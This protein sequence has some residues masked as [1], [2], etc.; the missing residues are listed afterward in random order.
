[1]PQSI[2]MSEPQYDPSSPVTIS[3]A[4]EKGAELQYVELMDQKIS[5][6]KKQLQMKQLDVED[7]EQEL[8]EIKEERASFITLVNALQETVKDQERELAL[9]R[10]EVID[11]EIQHGDDVYK[12]P[13]KRH[14]SVDEVNF[15]SIRETE[16]QDLVAARDTSL[17]QSGE[18]AQKLAESRAEADDLQER[19]KHTTTML[20][21][22]HNEMSQLHAKNRVLEAALKDSLNCSRSGSRF[23]SGASISMGTATRMNLSSSSVSVGGRSPSSKDSNQNEV[24]GIKSPDSPESPPSRVP[25]LVTFPED[26]M[27]ADDDVS[28]HS[29]DLDSITFDKH[30]ISSHRKNPRGMM[31][32]VKNAL[33]L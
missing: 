19:L 11:R 31:G 3:S 1:M 17:L 18:L 4:D 8:V 20:A 25:K 12:T 21:E 6:L 2:A 14:D 9:L 5:E 28:M 26:C 15:V 24:S 33:K 7:I 32:V 13:F 16:W 30:S 23:W 27:D 22:A 10:Q 29:H